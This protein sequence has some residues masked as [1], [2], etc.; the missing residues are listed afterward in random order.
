M[1]AA[2]QA[3][4]QPQYQ[5]GV[6]E[7]DKKAVERVH[8]D[9]PPLAS[10]VLVAAQKLELLKRQNASIPATTETPVEL[11]ATT[12]VVVGVPLTLSGWAPNYFAIARTGTDSGMSEHQ[13]TFRRSLLNA[14]TADHL[15]RATVESSRNPRVRQML[16]YLK[17]R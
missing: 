9:N 4:V 13:N 16:E 2:L 3:H 15:A 14:A 12:T 5:E 17:D 1:H 8:E 10:R 6:F 7:Y 11:P